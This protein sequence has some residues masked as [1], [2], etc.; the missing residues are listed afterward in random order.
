VISFPR[1]RRRPPPPAI[2]PTMPTMPAGPWVVVVG[3]HRSGTSAMTGALGALG[4][5]I[6]RPE[7]RMDW[8][9][10]NPEHW[11]SLSLALHDDDL[12]QRLGGTWDA[13]APLAPGWE[14]GAIARSMPDP[15]PIV[16][17][18][19][20]DPGPLVW[21]DPRIC[22]LLPYWRRLIPGPL[23]AVFVWRS[24]TAVAR[25][26]EKR[27]GLPLAAGIALWE[28]YNRS[29]LI[30]LR[31]VDTYV[32]Q[33]EAVLAEPDRTVESLIA[34]FDS[35]GRF[36]P[37][38]DRWRRTEAA[39]SLVSDLRHHAGD[40]DGLLLPEHHRML[41]F[42]RSLSGGHEP[43]G[44]VALLPESPWS[45]ALLE[46]RRQE[47]SSAREL[48]AAREALVSAAHPTPDGPAS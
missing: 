2:A 32:A 26:L 38:C 39:G 20:P 9:E 36:A 43:L 34:W 22:L 21:K 4:F 42:L 41:D 13:P 29:A 1:P 18:A 23:T 46:S 28:R 35:L 16:A 47:H 17:A 3:M 31:G 45:T 33:Y 24:P 8:P 11:E 15:A 6:N 40:D 7:D 10:S 37:L 12:V 44:P 27:D 14:D 48:A 30:G 5:Q 19:Y 25:S